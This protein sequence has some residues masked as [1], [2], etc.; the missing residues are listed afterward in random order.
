MAR[1]IMEAP[2]D[3]NCGILDELKG[4]VELVLSIGKLGLEIRSPRE[5]ELDG[6][7]VESHLL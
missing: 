2:M 6:F 7:W 1:V 5:A 4:I 3:S